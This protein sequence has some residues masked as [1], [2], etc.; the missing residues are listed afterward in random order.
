MTKKKKNEEET[1][2]REHWMHLHGFNEGYMKALEDLSWTCIDCGN[3]YQ[4]TVEACPN[5]LI[6]EARAR[7]RHTNYRLNNE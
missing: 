7:V 4:P 3:L 1:R 5:E 6:D 2:E